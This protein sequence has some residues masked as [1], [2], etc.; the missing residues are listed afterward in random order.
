MLVPGMRA[1]CGGVG[2]KLTSIPALQAKRFQHPT[3]LVVKSLGLQEMHFDQK[4]F[5]LAIYLYNAHG[6]CDS[7]SASIIVNQAL[8]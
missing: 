7:H 3:T 4:N 5:G 2:I 6:T 8:V 1:H